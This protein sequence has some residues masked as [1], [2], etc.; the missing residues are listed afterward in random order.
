MFLMHREVLGIRL[1][2]T[3]VRLPHLVTSPHKP[4]QQDQAAVFHAI[5]TMMFPIAEFAIP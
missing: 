5:H 1:W 2:T 4:C 3:E